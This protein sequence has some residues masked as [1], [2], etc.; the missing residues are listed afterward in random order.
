MLFLDGNLSLHGQAVLTRRRIYAGHKTSMTATK[1]QP[2]DTEGKTTHRSS[3]KKNSGVPIMCSRS[4]WN[5]HSRGSGFGKSCSSGNVN[6]SVP[7]DRPCILTTYQSSERALT[8]YPRFQKNTPCVGVRFANRI[9][10]RIADGITRKERRGRITHQ[11]TIAASA[12]NN[13]DRVAVRDT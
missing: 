1:I 9:G 3:W 2:S 11:N 10:M 6:S 5:S 8:T 4:F 12:E 7:A 13:D